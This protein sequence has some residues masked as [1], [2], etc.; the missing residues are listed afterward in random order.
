MGENT[1]LPSDINISK[2]V[3]VNIG[4]IRHFFKEYSISFLMICRLI[5]FTLV[6]LE[7]LMFKVSEIIGISKI[8]FFNFFGNERV[9]NLKCI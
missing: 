3:G 5:D 2:T 7:L 8:E 1:D 9:N 6:V 4:F